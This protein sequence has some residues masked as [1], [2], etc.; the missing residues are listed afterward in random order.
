MNITISNV[1]RQ[2][3]ME[4]RSLNCTVLFDGK[5]AGLALYD[6]TGGPLYFRWESLEMQSR[7]EQ[8]V[9][10]LPQIDVSGM[11]E[12]K[13]PWFKEL[14]PDGKMA[15]T[16]ESVIWD[17]V[18]RYEVGAQ[19]D[20]LAK[21]KVVYI[22]AD[23]K[24]GYAVYCSVKAQDAKQLAAWLANPATKEKL[25]AVVILNTLDR[26]AALDLFVAPE[27]AAAKPAAAAAAAAPAEKPQPESKP[28]APAEK[29]Q[30]KPA[31][32]Q[33]GP[34]LTLDERYELAAKLSGESVADLK[35]KF[36]SS[37][38]GQQAMALKRIIDKH[39]Q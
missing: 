2:E 32:K 4:D 25:N 38:N 11:P 37:N 22:R 27:K 18:E 7:Y 3:A 35:A 9:A 31:A 13:Q 23:G 29:P 1:K 20:R 28:A 5:K 15:Q 24:G 12:F 30:P 36:G 39:Q 6:G 10:A 16:E 21:S 26:E 14:Y 34:K 19:F 17:L 33:E 8:H